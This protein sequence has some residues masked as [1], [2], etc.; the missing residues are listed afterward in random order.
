[1]SN[2]EVLSPLQDT[3]A[4]IERLI[5]WD[6]LNDMLRANAH[7][8][9]IQGIFS[10]TP[11]NPADMVVLVRPPAALPKEEQDDKDPECTIQ[12]WG[13]WEA[14]DGITDISLIYTDAKT[15]VELWNYHLTREGMEQ[16]TSSTVDPTPLDQDDLQEIR[17]DCEEANWD[18]EA[19]RKLA[20]TV[21]FFS[22]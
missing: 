1:M 14:V 12:L 18:A 11:D 9:G 13:R 4:E 16:F 5:L 10:A 17:A 19:S 8:V 15:K 6:L 22:Y 7:E 21:L 20:A 3:Q 2:R